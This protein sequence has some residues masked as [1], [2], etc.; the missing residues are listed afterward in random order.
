MSDTIP[1]ALT[2][3]Q[4]ARIVSY[5]N[6]DN[7]AAAAHEIAVNN[8]A[9]PDRD[10]RKIT[11]EMIDAMKANAANSEGEGWPDHGLSHFAD[12]LASYLPPRA[13]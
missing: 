10:A 7:P 6:A 8:A 12:A 3:D 13:K 11:W 9:L 1:P 5:S 4:W 2:P